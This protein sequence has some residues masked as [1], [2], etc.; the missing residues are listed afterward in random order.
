VLRIIDAFIRVETSY[1][2]HRFQN[3]IWIIHTLRIIVL[4]IHEVFKI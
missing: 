4:R 1:N 2:S 3:Y